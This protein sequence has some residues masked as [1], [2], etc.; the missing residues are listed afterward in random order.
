MQIVPGLHLVDGMAGGIVNA[1]VWERSDGGLT[2]IDAGMPKDAAKIL[3]FGRTLGLER[4]D[5]II[6]THADID[7][8]G[9]LAEVQAATGA[10]VICHAVEKEVVEGRKIRAMGSGLL[11]RGYSPVLDGVTRLFMGYKPVA[12]VDELV[13]DKQVLPD[14]LQVIHVPG[15]TAGQIALYQPERGIL[16]VGDAF[17][18]NK[19]RLGL[20]SSVATPRKDVARDSI[21]KLAELKAVQVI[22][23]GHGTPITRDAEARLNAFAASLEK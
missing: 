2:L 1:Y 10:R 13:L 21:R 5:R 11:A 16:I 22:C 17:N 9:G 8:V 4:L 20:P 23:C 19:G 6:V 7:H 12:R 14:G 3:A 18:S 15:H